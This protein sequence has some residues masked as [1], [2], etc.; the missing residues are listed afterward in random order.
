MDVGKLEAAI[1]Q[2]RTCA[3]PVGPRHRSSRCR[4]GLFS[5]LVRSQSPFVS[6]P[7]AVHR[8]RL[9]PL[10]RG[11]RGQCTLGQ[12]FRS[13]VPKPTR[14]LAP[15]P[16]DRN[17]CPKGL[18]RAREN[19]R[20]MGTRRHNDPRNQIPIGSDGAPE[21][22]CRADF[23]NASNAVETVL[24]DGAVCPLLIR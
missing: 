24:P 18:T 21:Q 9:L 6:S 1:L 13:G 8:Y 10:G 17:R 11:R 16:P 3:C 20:G 19:G 7:S 12:R 4:R 14:Y 15:A 22:I 23:P 5:G 2:W